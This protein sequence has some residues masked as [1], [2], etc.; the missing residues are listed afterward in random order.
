MKRIGLV[1]GTT[2]ESTIE[3][4]RALIGLGR[5]VTTDPL[6][7]PVIVVYSVDL[8]EI[9]TRQR[10]GK[11]DEVVEIFSAAIE[12]LRLAGAELAALTANT[13]HVYFERLAARAEIPLVSIVAATCTRTA[14]LGCRRVLLLG[15]ETTMS[16]RM[17]PEA[18]AAHGIGVVVPDH[19]E[20]AFIDRT[21]YGELSL[22][23]TSPATRRTFVEICGRHIASAGVDGVIL[24][25]TEIPL[26]LKDGDLPVPMVDTTAVH[27]EAIFTA[28][29]SA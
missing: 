7:N 18:L 3:Y 2:P 24:A 15:T 16:S 12:S 5:Q 29:R 9:V 6:R 4:Y 28:A 19:E 13:P 10:A 22:G 26:L 1:G 27:A 17:Y 8:A 20:R 25:C 14:T 23:V 11:H 21:I